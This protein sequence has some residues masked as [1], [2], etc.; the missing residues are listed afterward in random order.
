MGL[1]VKE[2]AR[3]YSD[4]LHLLSLPKSY[5]MVH[6]FQI[7]FTEWRRIEIPVNHIPTSKMELF[8]KLVNNWKV[9]H[10]FSKRSIVDVW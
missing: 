7:W 2:D 5:P 3:F 9:F 8:A 10:F 6:L 1:L 4:Q